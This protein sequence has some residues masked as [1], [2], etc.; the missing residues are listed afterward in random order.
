MTPALFLDLAIVPA[1]RLLPSVMDSPEARAMVVAIALQETNLRARRQ[2]PSGPGR[3]F[4]QFE[5]GVAA[6]AEVLQHHATS[7]KAMQFC[8]LLC[9]DPSVNGVYAAVEYHDIL[10]AGFSRLLLWTSRVA[11]P[12]P[13][14][15]ES[16]WTLYV[17]R[18]KPGKPRH[19]DW[20]DSFSRGWNA[21]LRGRT[22]E[23]TLNA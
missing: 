14:D 19:E 23:P 13:N 17:D 16:G 5:P 3:G 10:C 8:Q 11:L 4:T 2:R 1:A 18:W 22:I 6:I 20:Y 9:V 15:P 21:V 7:L 12:G